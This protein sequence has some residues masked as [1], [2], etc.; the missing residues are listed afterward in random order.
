[1]MQVITT[2]TQKG[3]VTLPKAIRDA[4]NIDKYDKVTI[5]AKEDYIKIKPT[6]DILDLAGTLHPRKNNKKSALDARKYMEKH[7]K[8]F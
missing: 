2:V 7:Y 8:R 4:F 3:Q 5:E 1:M 6:I